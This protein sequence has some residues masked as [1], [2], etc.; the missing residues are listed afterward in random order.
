MSATSHQTRR[1]QSNEQRPVGKFQLTKAPSTTPHCS[2]L[3]ESLRLFLRCIRMPWRPHSPVR[4]RREP[5]GA[6]APPPGGKFFR[7]RRRAS[8]SA[9]R[10]PPGSSAC[11]RSAWQI[12]PRTRHKKEPQ[13]R[14]IS[15]AGYVAYRPVQR[16]ERGGGASQCQS[17]SP[18]AQRA[19]N[20][21]QLRQL[22]CN[23]AEQSRKKSATIEMMP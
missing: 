10:S 4:A 3:A 12:G 8:Q 16:T 15:Y 19:R 14:W 23:F 7:K 1:R 20:A 22:I 13:A 9:S 11:E 6:A 2:Q 18:D 21:S 17:P 5:S